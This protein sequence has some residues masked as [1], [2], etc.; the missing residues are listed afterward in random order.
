MEAVVGSPVQM[1]NGQTLAEA[2]RM[3]G[4]GFLTLAELLIDG[5]ADTL[6]S[7]PENI[8]QKPPLL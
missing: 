1:E 3:I 7:Q 4:E 8:N 2:K 6:V 5:G